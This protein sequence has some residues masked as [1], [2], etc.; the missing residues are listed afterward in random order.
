M[1]SLKQHHF[2]LLRHI[3][4]RGRLPASELDGR[5]LRPLR[6]P[7]LVVEHHGYVLPTETA[8]RLVTRG[9]RARLSVDER[10]RLGRNVPLFRL[11]QQ[12]SEVEPPESDPPVDEHA[13]RSVHGG[14]RRTQRPPDDCLRVAAP[15]L[16]FPPVVATDDV[17]RSQAGNGFAGTLLRN[18]AQVLDDLDLV[19]DTARQ[20]EDRSKLRE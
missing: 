2:E 19:L 5:A 12:V 14:V 15:Q 8:R 6:G 10:H 3:V 13:R 11:V 16:R 7:E 18:L 9:L 4:E 20:L 17:E 1:A